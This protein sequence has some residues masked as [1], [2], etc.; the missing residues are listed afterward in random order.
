MNRLWHSLRL[1]VHLQK[2]ILALFKTNLDYFKLF[3]IIDVYK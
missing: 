3:E 1:Y 2:S